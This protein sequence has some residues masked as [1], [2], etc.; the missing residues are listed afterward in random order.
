MAYASVESL[1]LWDLLG[2]VAIVH[3]KYIHMHVQI[4]IDCK[5]PS[6]SKII[7]Q[8]QFVNVLS[9]YIHIHRQVE[10]VKLY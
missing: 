6:R 7:G 8:L 4:E 2:H 1:P 3:T 9:M 10:A 5:M